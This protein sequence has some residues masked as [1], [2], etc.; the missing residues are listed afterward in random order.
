M[1]IEYSMEIVW[2]YTM[3]LVMQS[4]INFMVYGFH[5]FFP[6]ESLWGRR[7]KFQTPP[8]SP[9][10]GEIFYSGRDPQ[11]NTM[12]FPMFFFNFSNKA[13]GAIQFVFNNCKPR[14]T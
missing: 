1:D 9:T 7:K 10:L 13:A 5:K 14:S 2:I 4:Q 3:D 8:L 12:Q 6:V 11:R